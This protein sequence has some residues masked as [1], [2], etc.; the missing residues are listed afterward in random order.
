MKKRMISWILI[1][2]LLAMSSSNVQAASDVSISLLANKKVE[3]ALAVGSTAVDYSHFEEQLRASIG[4]RIPEKNL[5]IMA[6]NS[7]D[8]STSKEFEWSVFDHSLNNGGESND[9]IEE[10]GNQSSTV[11]DNLNRHISLDQTNGTKLIFKGY[12]MS[13]YSDFMLLENNQTTK[14]KIQFDIK[15]YF[16]ADALHNIGFFFNSNV[17]YDMSKYNGIHAMYEAYQ[18][19]ELYLNGYLMTLEYNGYQT[20]GIKIYQVNNLALKSFHHATSGILKIGQEEQE[21]KQYESS[22]LS[23]EQFL[24]TLTDENQKIQYLQTIDKLKQ[25]LSQLREKQ[26]FVSI[27]CLS[28]ENRNRY[29]ATDDLRKFRI[30]VS[31][32]DITVYYAG[33]DDETHQV[34]QLKDESIAQPFDETSNGYQAFAN[35]SYDELTPLTFTLSSDNHDEVTTIP[36]DTTFK[37]GGSDFGPMVKY[38]N[39]GCPQLT[40]VEF[41]NLT[42][43]T[44]VIRSLNEVIREPQWEKDSSKFLVN[45]NEDSILD[46]DNEQI[47][48][49]L[50]NRLQNDN[51][52]YVGWGSNQNKEQS[53]AFLVKND[54][55]GDFINIEDEA[56]KTLDA[57]MERLADIIVARYESEAGT[58]KGEE[59]E[60]VTLGKQI[61]FDVSGAETINTVDEQYPQGKWTVKHYDILGNLVSTD[62]KSNLQT[63]YTMPGKYEIY[64]CGTQPENKIKTLIIN[65][66]PKA[67]FQVKIVS[68]EAISLSLSNT[69]S[70][71]EGSSLTSKWIYSEVGSVSRPIEF[72]PNSP[73]LMEE[74][75]IYLVSLTVTDQWGASTTI[76]RQVSFDDRESA[77]PIADFS[78]STTKFIRNASGASITGSNLLTITDKSYDLYGKSVTSKFTFATGAAIELNP[79]GEKVGMYTLDTSGLDAGVYTIYLTTNNGKNESKRVAHAFEIIEDKVGPNAVSNKKVG[80]A[81]NGS[82][83]LKLAFSDEGIGFL[84][85]KSVLSKKAEFTQEDWEK[86]P[87]SYLDTKE[88]L[89]DNME[90]TYYIHY[91][92][93][94]ALGNTETNCIG[95]YIIDTNRPKI[96]TLIYPVL[97]AKEEVVAPHIQFSVSEEV[98]KG[99]GYLLIKRASDDSVVYSIASV[100]KAVRIDE[101]TITVDT[102]MSL[103]NETKYYISLTNGFLQDKVGNELAEMA[104]KEAWSFTTKKVS[105]KVKEKEITITGFDVFQELENESGEVEL[106][107]TKAPADEKQQ[108]FTVHVKEAENH[109]SYITL[110]PNFSVTPSEDEVSITVD[111]G[112]TYKKN[113]NNG[114]DFVIPME[115]GPDDNKVEITVKGKTYTVNFVSYG[116]EWNNFGTQVVAEGIEVRVPK[117]SLANAVDISRINDYMTNTEINVKFVV[118]ANEEIIPE[119]DKKALKEAVKEDLKFLDLKVIKSVVIDDV[120]QED[121]II[122]NTLAPIKVRL[123][124]PKEMQESRK[125]IVVYRIHD[126]VISKLESTLVNEGKE[127]EFESDQYSTY[128]ISYGNNENNGSSVVPVIEKEKIETEDKNTT[129]TDVP[130]FYMKKNMSIGNRFRLV[131]TGVSKNSS[132]VYKTTNK[133]IVAVS[134]KGMM[135]AKANGTAI[136]TV[137]ITQ[138]G[139][140]YKTKIKVQVREGIPYNRTISKKDA[141]SVKIE[142]PVFNMYK[143]IQVG[144]RTKIQ[145]KNIDKNAVVTYSTDKKSI[146]TV[147]KNGSIRAKAKGSCIITAKIKQNGKVYCYKILVRV[148]KA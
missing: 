113:E 140:Q 135:C 29:K 92:A 34:E 144:N 15:E 60:I 51:I 133:K 131:F 27:A 121:E 126:G 95:P 103:D 53:E 43:E 93:V 8:T 22:L 59:G 20:T 99:T 94:D 119:S 145:I 7:V 6:T 70:D 148:A 78:L 127:I 54:L 2:V 107:E 73:F 134:S 89:M 24:E 112:I 91:R 101:K 87:Y 26:K 30:E 42:M 64:Y 58:T 9:F 71:L 14:K 98:E 81:L 97:N 104:G 136:I 138:N 83:E 80:E 44:E 102:M 120:A 109:K 105:E 19:D 40:K 38:A 74:G 118:T 31:P 23:Y 129:I 48:G 76:S 46:F 3:V 90:G 115:I 17:T 33:F 84:K 37:S 111:N 32:S 116:Q 141:V 79:V 68:G 18:A 28:T 62:T 21:I 75:K 65:E 10:T 85:Q 1:F 55:K 130:T 16:A 137:V 41:S 147:S 124:L 4:D 100:N 57:Q 110:K 143:K 52:H 49:E 114:Y 123:S 117:L 66:P 128:A 96:E 67:D 86:V 139:S 122:H 45:L 108:E 56:T 146:A 82:S 12:G 35:T 106:S 39:H 36:L 125:E 61:A 13:A 72:N 47:S 25:R 11:Y 88:F 5:N 50:L 77:L 69:S 63:E 132:V 142:L